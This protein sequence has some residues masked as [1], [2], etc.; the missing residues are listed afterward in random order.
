[1]QV[2]QLKTL[3]FLR[4]L[5]HF[6]PLTFFFFPYREALSLLSQCVKCSTSAFHPSFHFPN[7]LLIGRLTNLAKLR[8]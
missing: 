4:W 6:T 8:S 3:Y 5:T 2:T 1:M 7:K